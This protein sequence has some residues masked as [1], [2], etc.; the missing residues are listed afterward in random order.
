M[1]PLR[2]HLQHNPDLYPTQANT[3]YA[4]PIYDAKPEVVRLGCRDEVEK[5]E[6]ELFCRFSPF[7]E[8]RQWSVGN[9][10]H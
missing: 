2:Q 7:S 6:Y 10:R 8:K 3:S 4:D 5:E 9:E 1:L